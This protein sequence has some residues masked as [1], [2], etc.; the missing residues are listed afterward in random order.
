MDILGQINWISCLAFTVLLLLF[1]FIKHISGRMNWTLVILVSMALGC[2]MGILFSS[3]NN[4]YLKSAEFIGDMYVG[5]ITLLAVPVILISIISSFISLKNKDNMKKIGAR[6]VVWLMIPAAIAIVLSIVAGV[7]L[8]IGHNASSIFDAMSEVSDSS[9][10]AYE[11]L[12][13]SFYDVLLGLFPS[14]IVTDI[15]NNNVV[16]II[17]IAVAISAAYISVAHEEG[18]DKVS[19]F[20]DFIQAL[21][22]IIYK[23]LEYVIDLTPYAVCCLIAASASNI[24]SNRAAILQFLLLVAVIYAVSLIHI[25]VAGGLLV[26]FVAKIN[27]IRFFHRIAPAQATAFTTQSS[28]GTLPVNINCLK[29]VGVD[30]EVANFTAPLGT[31]VGM[32]ACTCIWPVL[33]VIFYVHAAGISWGIGDYILLAVLALLLSFGSAGVPGIAVVSAIAL[34]NVLGLPTAAVILLTPINTISDMIRTTDNV[35]SAAVAA[36]VVARKEDLLHD[37]FSKNKENRA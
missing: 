31:T 24:F 30:E 36:T 29:K 18:E 21:K 8:N 9:V 37:E 16:A 6:S 11:G 19:I 32:P 27:P 22:K 34:F 35:T 4:V 17:I 15:A 26:R 12:R 33:L 7:V 23:I 14:N 13:S 25:Y 5:V 10:S 20:K 28:V 2:A 3:E 1:V